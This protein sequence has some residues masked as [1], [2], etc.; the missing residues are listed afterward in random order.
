MFDL[1]LIH[2]IRNL[3]KYFNSN[4]ATFNICFSD[5]SSAMRT[6]YYARLNELV[7]LLQFDIAFTKK[8]ESFPLITITLNQSEAD[9]DTML[10]NTGHAGRLVMF[11]NQECRVNIYSKNMDDIRILHNLILHGLLLFKSSFFDTNYLDLR[12]I[13]SN[14]LDPIDTLT[15]DNAAVYQRQMIYNSTK[16]IEITQIPSGPVF[17]LPWELD[18]T[19]IQN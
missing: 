15:S 4:Q 16:Q 14:D 12:Y 18:A 8:T 1:H 2:A 17:D 19:I 9:T 5:V 7:N 11:T 3:I 6:K 13:Q 10:G